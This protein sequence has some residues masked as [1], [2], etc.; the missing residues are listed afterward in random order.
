MTTQSDEEYTINDK[1]YDSI[2]FNEWQEEHP[3]RFGKIIKKC[4]PIEW[5][6]R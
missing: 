4:P 6:N 3:V 2:E 5:L 1:V